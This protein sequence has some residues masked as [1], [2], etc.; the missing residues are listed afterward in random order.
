MFT[1]E[2]GRQG[3]I[4]MLDGKRLQLSGAE[5]ANLLRGMLVDDGGVPA[6]VPEPATLVLVAHGAL[7]EPRLWAAA[8][9]GV[10]AAALAV[11]GTW[12]TTPGCSVVAAASPGRHTDGAV[13]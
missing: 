11:W 2:E 9:N 10:L 1:P 13:A 7:V 12:Q 5:L 4:V 8:G 3:V 6:L